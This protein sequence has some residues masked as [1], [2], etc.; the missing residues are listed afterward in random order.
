[1]EKFTGQ[2]ELLNLA[3]QAAG[4]SF[5]QIQQSAENAFLAGRETFAEA[6]KTLDDLTGGK[7][8][9]KQ[10]DLFKSLGVSG[11]SLSVDAFKK[12]GSAILNNGGTSLESLNEYLIGQ[13]ANK[14]EVQKIFVAMQNSGIDSLEEI[15]NASTELVITVGNQLQDLKFPFKETSDETSKIL[16]Q[17][18]KIR[19]STTKAT[20]DLSVNISDDD[21]KL[22]LGYGLIR[23]EDIKSGQSS[24]TVNW[25]DT[26]MGITKQQAKNRYKELMKLGK[27]NKANAYKAKY[28]QFF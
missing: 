20:I 6:R 23:P 18:D 2:V 28:A 26:S 15:K 27:T 12:I 21:R 10:F 7:D 17:M 13:G 14:D 24:S 4:V 3:A 9:K 25:G 1:M 19:N 11:G 5:Q 8:A 22:L 16:D